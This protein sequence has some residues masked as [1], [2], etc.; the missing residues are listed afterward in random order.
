MQKKDTE[1][2]K[3]SYEHGHPAREVIV[4]S[5]AE[6]GSET[7]SKEEVKRE[8]VKD[9]SKEEK[10]VVEDSMLVDVPDIPMPDAKAV[11]G[12]VI[13]D[14]CAGAFRLAFIGTGQGGSRIAEAFYKLGYR[15][16]CCVNTTGQDLVGISIPEENKLIMDVGSGGAGK[17]MEKGEEASRRYYEDIYDLMRRS[18]GKK[19]DRIVVCV[20]A[21]GGT[22][23]GSTNTIIEIAHDIAKSFRIEDDDGKPAVGVIASLPKVSEGAKTNENAYHLVNELLGL[24][25]TSDGKMD[26]RTISPLVIVDNDRIERIYPNLPVAKFWKVANQS[27]SGLLHLFNNIAVQDSDYTTFDR[28]DL[29]DILGS[30]V[31]SFGACPLTKWEQTTDISHAIRD[32]LKNNVLVGGFDT[33]QARAAAC[34]FVGSPDV[35]DEIP[36]EHLEHGFEML[37]RTMRQGGVVHRGIYK[38]SKPGLVVYSILGELGSPEER[39]AEIARTARVEEQK[40]RK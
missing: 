38:G 13:D 18:F 2:K 21:G 22:G 29:E 26:G 28:A 25:G 15:R 27:I 12:E 8:P 19:F 3:L 9:E 17:N 23:G 16:V 6:K 24:V 4:V 39:M 37:S 34:V 33:S 11:E 10:P 35:L 7:M 5:N 36:Q 30:G 14:E 20:G 1:W 40:G 31:V 32:N